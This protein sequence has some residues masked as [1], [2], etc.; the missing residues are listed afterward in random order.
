MSRNGIV[1]SGYISSCAEPIMMKAGDSLKV[2]DRQTDWIGWVWCVHPSGK[3]SW[4]PENFIQREGDTALATQEYDATELTA[5]EGQKLE[6][7]DE[8]AGWYWCKSEAG[9]SGWV[10]AENV[11]VE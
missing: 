4:V 6:I 5:A 8:E 3:S 10:P 9:D 11:K 1:A 2:E 7:V